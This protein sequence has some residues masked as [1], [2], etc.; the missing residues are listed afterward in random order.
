MG[1]RAFGAITALALCAA[2]AGP[3]HA[4]AI[5]GLSASPVCP[6]PVVAGVAYTAAPTASDPTPAPTRVAPN[7]AGSGTIT[8]SGSNLTAA[9]CTPTVRIGS[10]TFTQLAAGT[11]TLTIALT[12]ATPLPPAASGAVAAMLTDALGG[13]NSSNTGSVRVFNLLQT[14]A[15]SAQDLAPVEGSTEHVSGNAFTPFSAPA[16]N[17][18]PG[19]SVAGVY[20]SCF[21]PAQPA[22]ATVVPTPA[23]PGK[24][25]T[26]DTALQL[27]APGTYCDGPLSLT[28]TAPYFEDP[29]PAVNIPDCAAPQPQNCVRLTVNADPAAPIDVAFAVTAV[30]PRAVD[31]GGKLAVSG[32]GFGPSGR[33]AI[34]GVEAPVTW[35][36]HGIQVTVPA[37]ASTA[38]LIVQRLTGDHDAL[39]L[40]TV[41]VSTS[42]AVATRVPD[43]ST[44]VGTHNEAAGPSSD[45]PPE[46]ASQPSAPALGQDGLTIDLAATHASPCSDVAFSVKLEVG[47]HGVSGATVVLSVVS[48]PGD[49]ASVAPSAAV[50]DG[51]GIGRGTLHLS[52][53]PGDHLLLAQSGI[54]S[55]EVHVEG[56]GPVS[57]GGVN[58]PFGVGPLNIKVTGN[59]LVIWLSVA[60][61]I[62]VALGVLVN[63]EVLRRW[64]WSVTGAR[65][66][67]RWRKAEMA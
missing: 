59:P 62:L 54:Y 66:V 36:D 24:P 46:A 28:F 15:A 12:P 56:Q 31:T 40:G 16:H 1:A 37:G 6:T 41:A 49:D 23:G 13:T 35:S 58:L 39:D 52:G 17:G 60:T 14:P 42:A 32:T 57:A 7:A 43:D 10:A 22:A 30:E 27:P 50:T 45:S 5:A 63:L 3:R 19:A 65:F 26:Y 47:G 25:P 48:A 18:L 38:H 53:K 61:A 44:P 55:A 11:N 34:G 4:A 9:G 67:A 29:Q 2:L 51:G 64:A 8:V 21:G 33:A 20:A